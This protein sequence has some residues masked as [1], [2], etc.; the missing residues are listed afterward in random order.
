MRCGRSIQKE[1]VQTPPE[2]EETKR[3]CCW[4][5]LNPKATGG[6]EHA[7]RPEGPRGSGRGSIERRPEG[8]ADSSEIRESE[9]HL[10]C[11]AQKRGAV[12]KQVFLFRDSPA[13]F[14][15]FYKRPFPDERKSHERRRFFESVYGSHLAVRRRSRAIRYKGPDEAYAVN[16]IY[17][18]L[19]SETES[20]RNAYGSSGYH[21]KV[22]RSSG[23]QHRS[24]GSAVSRFFNIKT[25]LLCAMI[26]TAIVIGYRES[27]RPSRGYYR[28]NGNYYYYDS[29]DWY[30]YDDG[31]YYIAA[32]DLLFDD[33]D[34]YYVSN[35]YDDGYTVD[36]FRNSEY[37]D[38]YYERSYDDDYGNN[39]DYD[40]Y[41]DDD[42]Y[43]WDWDYDDWDFGGTDWDTDW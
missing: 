3:V 20:R 36:D 35:D 8:E 31:W 1:K 38:G 28:N 37:Y 43:D 11:Q 34:D 14:I 10:R 6:P 39:D 13:R 16:E 29:N 30:Y 32:E 19:K 27:K 15:F 22:S 4:N 26:L 7:G 25:F 18:K 2:D 5:P 17:E 42:D 9:S 21:S 24:S 12:S 23:V 40:Y 41:D 33:Y